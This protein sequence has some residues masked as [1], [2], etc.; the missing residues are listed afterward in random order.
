[1]SNVQ[2]YTWIGVPALTVLIGIS[3][4]LDYLHYKAAIARFDGID[5]LE[6]RLDVLAG[7]ASGL[8]IR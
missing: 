1:M 7:K 3:I 2:I 5:A 4:L 6:S 8:D